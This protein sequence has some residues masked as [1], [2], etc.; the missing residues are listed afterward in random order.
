[1]PIRRL[2]LALASTASLAS[3]T[4]AQT[5]DHAEDAPA[6]A[7]S[8]LQVAPQTAPRLGAEPTF[9]ALATAPHAQPSGFFS[10]LFSPL[11]SDIRHLATRDTAFVLAVGGAAALAA[12]PTDRHFTHSLSTNDPVENALDAGTPIG[13]GAAQVGA[14]FGAYLVGRIAG[15]PELAHVGADLFRAQLLDTAMVQG[16]KLASGRTRPDGSSYS[17]P[18]GHTSSAF[19]TATVLQRH[20]GWK[21]GL[22]AYA[23]AAYVGG[24]RMAENRHYLSDVL[25]GAAL[26]IVAGH[27]VTVGHGAHQFALTP[28][29]VPGGAGVRFVHLGH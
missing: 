23:V 26:G 10:A 27:A 18:S 5:I 28:V 19:A 14:A 15:K 20:Y 4:F 9:T 2:L 13:S 1:M 12:H 22:P 6:V 24:S 29:A 11:G 25:F 21:V 7:S 17:F 8:V 16:L 3:P